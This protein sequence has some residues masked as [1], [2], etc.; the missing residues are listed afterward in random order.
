MPARVYASGTRLHSGAWNH[1]GTTLSFAATTATVEASAM[2]PGSYP[3]RA[4]FRMVGASNCIEYDF[5]VAGQVD[6]RASAQ[7]E[8]VLYRSGQAPEALASPDHDA[9]GAQINYFVACVRAG[10]AP[11]IA[12]LAEARAVLSIALAA[13]ESLE[14]GRAVLL[15]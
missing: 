3:F 2:M 13:K 9:Y 1:V 12:T 14:T 15:A 11:T 4:G 8:F 5:R 6:Q 7:N 10:R